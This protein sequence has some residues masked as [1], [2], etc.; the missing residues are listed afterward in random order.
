MFFDDGSITVEECGVKIK[1]IPDNDSI[2]PGIN[3]YINGEL[4]SR[5]EFNSD[6]G[7]ART[8]A[9]NDANDEP[10]NITDYNRGEID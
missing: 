4:I 9:Y 10:A 3:I 8:I 5:T 6:T 7:R 1:A 2:Y